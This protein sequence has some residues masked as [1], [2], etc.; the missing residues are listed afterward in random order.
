MPRGVKADKSAL[1]IYD[2]VAVRQSDKE[3]AIWTLKEVWIN[4]FGLDNCEVDVK[5]D[6]LG[7]YLLFP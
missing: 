4:H 5:A 1:P 6:D 3:S 7:K 2:A